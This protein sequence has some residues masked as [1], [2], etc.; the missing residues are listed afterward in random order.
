MSDPAAGFITG[1]VFLNPTSIAGGGTELFP[2]NR[3][4][5]FSPGL[6]LEIK[7][8]GRRNRVIRNPDSEA[9]LTLPLRGGDA[10]TMELL[11]GAFTDDGLGMAPFGAGTVKPY[12]DMPDSRILVIPDDAADSSRPGWRKYLFFCAA[13]LHPNTG[14]I[15]AY[16]PDEQHWPEDCILV[17]SMPPNLTAGKRPWLKRTA[18]E[19][20]AEYGSNLNTFTTE[21]SPPAP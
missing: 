9:T 20:V 4:V 7:R 11:Q 5:Y 18:A 2:E 16:S 15:I 13:Q 12:Q 8:E 17:A 19:I 21:E 10:A 3:V 1:R 6:N 14:A